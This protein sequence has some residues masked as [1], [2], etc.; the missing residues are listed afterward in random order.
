LFSLL[1]ALVLGAGIHLWDARQKDNCSLYMAGDK[2]LPSSELVVSGSRQ[3]EVPC[4]D[5][6]M[7]QPLSV[8]VLCLL[9]L[10]IWVVFFFNALADLQRGLQSRRH[11]RGLS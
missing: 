11:M 9:D 3:I 5:W 4:S 2:S 1:F 6:I 7:R 10:V 8:Q